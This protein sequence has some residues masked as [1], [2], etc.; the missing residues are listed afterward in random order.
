MAAQNLQFQ[1]TANASINDLKAQVGQLATTMNQMQTQ[2][3]G[4]LPA[5]TVRNPNVSAITLRSGKEVAVDT[6]ADTS[7][8]KN[9]N[10]EKISQ[11]LCLHLHLLHLH[12]NL[13]KR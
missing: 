2:G 5:Q 8:E 3:S 11:L 7:G 4:S 10:I 1:Q 6:S 9:K 12:P 13:M